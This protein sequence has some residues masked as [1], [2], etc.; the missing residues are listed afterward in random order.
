M[1]DRAGRVAG[2]AAAVLGALAK[3]PRHADEVARTAGVAPGTA[4]SALLLL[5][6][7]GL[8]EQRP[9]HYFVRRS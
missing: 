6:L 1:E 5:E 4:L 2:E 7:E 9:G 8:C 3:V